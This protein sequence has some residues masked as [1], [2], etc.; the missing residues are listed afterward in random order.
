[1]LSFLFETGSSGQAE[2]GQPAGDPVSRPEPREPGCPGDPLEYMQPMAVA[3]RGLTGEQ[4]LEDE[5]FGSLEP[6]KV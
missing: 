5:G 2:T 1:M 6:L 3:L 4:V